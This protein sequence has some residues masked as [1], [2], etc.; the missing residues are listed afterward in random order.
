MQ[1]QFRLDPNTIKNVNTDSLS[2]ECIAGKLLIA[3]FLALKAEGFRACDIA[4]M[5]SLTK[6]NLSQRAGIAL[7]SMIKVSLGGQQNLLLQEMKRAIS[8]C[9]TK[10]DEFVEDAENSVNNY[11]LNL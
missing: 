6:N 1:F 11:C 9:C 3:Y 5:E 4:F 7:Y 2:A 8:I 10:D